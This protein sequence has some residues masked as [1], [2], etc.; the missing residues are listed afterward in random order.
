MKDRLQGMKED[1]H[2][3]LKRYSQ[4]VRYGLYDVPTKARLAVVYLL[5]DLCA[6]TAAPQKKR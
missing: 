4:E 2:E 6:R 5:G 3:R 1:L